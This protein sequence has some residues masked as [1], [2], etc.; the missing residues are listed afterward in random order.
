MNGLIMRNESQKGDSLFS[1]EGLADPPESVD[2]RSKGY[3]TPIK[4]QVT[5][6]RKQP[7]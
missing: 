5:S 4:N 7:L 1:T 3:V 6:D 2:W